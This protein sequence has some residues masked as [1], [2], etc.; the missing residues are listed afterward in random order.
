MNKNIVTTNLSKAQCDEMEML[1][2]R[3]GAT[4]F[5]TKQL[6]GLFTIRA[7]FDE[8]SSTEPETKPPVEKPK[9]EPKPPVDNPPIEEHLK[10]TSLLEKL[11]SIYKGHSIQ[12]P[13]LRDVTLA[14]WLLESGRATSELATQDYN[15]G[16]LK[17]RT[18]MTP[19]ATSITYEAHD[20]IDQ[21][22]KFATIESFIDGY[23]A[24]IKR[25][26]YSGWE[27]H[28]SSGEAFINFIG[29]IYCPNQGYVDKVLAL[30]PE[31]KKLLA[32]TTETSIEP[33][34]R[35][36]NANNV[37]NQKV[38]V[39]D[40]GHGEVNHAVSYTGVEEKKLNLDFALLLEK[41]IHEKTPTDKNIKTVLT[42]RSDVNVSISDRAAIAGANK[43]DLFL[44]IHF[45]GLGSNNRGTETFYRD[46][47]NGNPNLKKDME[48]ADVV[49]KATF[50]GLKAIDQNAKSRG[51]KPDTETKAKSLGVLN[52]E[53]LGIQCAACLLEVECI[54]NSVVDKLLI[55]GT[56]ALTNRE[57]VM[58][59]LALAIIDYVL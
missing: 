46:A 47:K 27:Q 37:A 9:P 24:F 45:N 21:Y 57:T 54:E 20:G 25:P 2:K 26:P 29:P 11:V 48:F 42:R 43:A 33:G 39:I 15:F 6:D 5:V 3:R 13:Q 16:G 51:I 31:A 1:Y 22:C 56:D 38:I 40:P 12:Y 32:E 52:H 59:N 49:Q 10:T 44:S 19:Y 55:S 50:T 35:L 58:R 41:L 36:N 30:L 8:A 4:V 23:W 28:I 7:I 17:W 34:H 53:K 14:Q 18:E